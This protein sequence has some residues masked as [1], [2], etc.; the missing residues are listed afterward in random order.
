[1]EQHMLQL[2]IQALLLQER[3]KWS[4]IKCILQCHDTSASACPIQS[5]VQQH[6]PFEFSVP[7]GSAKLSDHL[8][9][10]GHGLHWAMTLPEH[11]DV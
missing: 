10:R 1:M 2:F 9:S 11:D 8:G 3:T 6:R 7:R 5:D 4:V